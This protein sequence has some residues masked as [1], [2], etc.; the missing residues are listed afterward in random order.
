MTIKYKNKYGIYTLRRRVQ[1]FGR[2]DEAGVA[3][4]VLVT[5]RESGRAMVEEHSDQSA[6]AVF[7]NHSHKSHSVLG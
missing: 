4:L 1:C 3:D 7:F 5:G 2:D 6:L